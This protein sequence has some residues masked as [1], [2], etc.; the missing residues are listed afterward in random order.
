MIHESNKAKEAY[1][2]AIKL[3]VTHYALVV[4]Y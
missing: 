3:M 4:K 2:M 1:N